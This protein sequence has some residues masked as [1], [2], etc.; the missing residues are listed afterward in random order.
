MSCDL[1]EALRL[2]DAFHAECGNDRPSDGAAFECDFGNQFAVLYVESDS[3]TGYSIAL[4]FAGTGKT[5]PIEL[6]NGSNHVGKEQLALLITACFENRRPELLG[7]AKAQPFLNNV[8]ETAP[9]T[10]ESTDTSTSK[11]NPRR[12]RFHQI[13]DARR[14][15]VI[16]LIWLALVMTVHYWILFRYFAEDALFLWVFV[17]FTGLIALIYAAM[18][19]VHVVRGGRWWV[20]LDGSRL[21]VGFPPGDE[22]QSYEIDVNEIT[23]VHERRHGYRGMPI[24]EFALETNDLDHPRRSFPTP[25]EFRVDEFLQALRDL[26]PTLEYRLTDQCRLSQ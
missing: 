14:A 26:R 20:I 13:V 11:A 2:C 9:T 23:G 7:W 16:R 8:E 3:D 4:Q 1:A 15:G 6:G 12:S 17:G 19:L 22:G 18:T 25:E 24:R 10:S 21:S 5:P